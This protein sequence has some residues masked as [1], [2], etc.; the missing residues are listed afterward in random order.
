MEKKEQKSYILKNVSANLNEIG[1]NNKIRGQSFLHNIDI[2]IAMIHM[3]FINHVYDF[4]ITISVSIRVNKVEEII[5]NSNGYLKKSEQSKTSTIGCELGNLSNGFQKRYEVFEDTK[6]DNVVNEIIESIKK[7]A[8]PFIEK[9][10][11]LYNIYSIVLKDDKESWMVSPV[12]YHRAQSAIVLAKILQK[13]NYEIVYENKKRF[14][15]EREEYGLDLFLK[16]YKNLVNI[17]F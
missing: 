4:D 13:A 7:H 15:E 16:L 9:Y 11:N 1:F 14:L 12:H 6:L 2:G 5:N 8:F 10:S 17:I 3:S